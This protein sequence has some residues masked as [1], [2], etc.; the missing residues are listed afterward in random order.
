V[1][2]DRGGAVEQQRAGLPTNA[3]DH[4][5]RVGGA[6]I[7]GEHTHGVTLLA[8]RA[9]R[10]HVAT[11]SGATSMGVREVA[12]LRWASRVHVRTIDEPAGMTE[13]LDLGV[14]GIMT[15]HID[16]PRDV[17]AER[18]HWPAEPAA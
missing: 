8:G 12:A 4:R 6:E 10:A 2:E 18:G 15:D 9:G 3:A 16:V 11:V 5:H 1:R 14:G 17:Y 13:L 7:D